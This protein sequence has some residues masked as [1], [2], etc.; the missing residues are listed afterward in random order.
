MP[1][2]SAPTF[3]RKGLSVLF[4]PLVQLVLL[5]W[6]LHYGLDLRFGFANTTDFDF[7]LPVPV[8]FFF[9]F[10]ALDSAKPLALR[11]NRWGLLVNLVSLSLFIAFNQH[12]DALTA[13]APEIANQV[14]FLLLTVVALSAGCIWLRPSDYLKNPNR[15]AFIPCLFIGSSLYLY[16]NAWRWLWLAFGEATSFAI[17]KIFQFVP[18]DFVVATFT[19]EEAVRLDHPALSVRIGRGCGGGDAVFFFVLVFALMILMN[20]KRAKKIHWMVSFVVGLV[21][22]FGINLFRIVLLFFVGIALRKHLG[23]EVGTDLFKLLFHTHLGWLL[24]VGGIYMYLRLW[25][26][27]T[28]LLTSEKHWD[29]RPMDQSPTGA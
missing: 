1:P 29:F 5:R 12:Y 16:Q 6:Y 22:M 8:A 3:V 21:W 17:Q 27:A 4:W 14:W 19:P 9:L 23:V 24:Y 11:L 28:K 2:K 10:Y 25:D 18:A 13:A 7:L 26:S 15:L 20:P